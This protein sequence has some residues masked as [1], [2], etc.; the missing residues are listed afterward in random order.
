MFPERLQ[1]SYLPIVQTLRGK[2]GIYRPGSCGYTGHFWS[3]TCG[4]WR[5]IP[6]E[7]DCQNPAFRGLAVI[8]E[9]GSEKPVVGILKEILS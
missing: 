6:G 1:H 2:T 7:D 5:P 3:V 4:Y 9:N 8:N